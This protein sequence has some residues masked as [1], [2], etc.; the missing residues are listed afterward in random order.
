M[1]GKVVQTVSNQ[2]KKVGS[3][4]KEAFVPPGPNH[5]EFGLT[6]YSGQRFRRSLSPEGDCEPSRVSCCIG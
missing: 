2:P 1:V 4:S 5:F 3:K 6:A